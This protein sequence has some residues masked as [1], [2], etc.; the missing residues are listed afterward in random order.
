MKILDADFTLYDIEQT[1][2]EKFSTENK[3]LRTIGDLDLSYEDYKYL[4]FRLKGLTKYITR[5]EVFEQYKLS[6]VT[7]FVF[8]ITY[9]EDTKKVYKEIG[10]LLKQFQQHQ[11]RYY[12]R[13]CMNVFFGL[14]LSTFG[15]GVTS[16]DDVFEVAVLHANLPKETAETIFMTLDEYFSQGETY[17]MEEELYDRLDQIIYKK[18]PFLTRNKG[19]LVYSVMLKEM[20][21][22][23]FISH[24]SLKQLLTEYNQVSMNLVESCYM[25]FMQHS[26]H[27]NRLV[28]IRS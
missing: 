6:I 4:V 2:E 11:V 10:R 8:A 7:A 26:N 5:T 27:N 3:T 1:L 19:Y 15:N 12:I 14:G 20:Y 25:W 16:I 21:S 22:S 13:I 23:C 9:E 18:Y 28:K 17:L 24:Y